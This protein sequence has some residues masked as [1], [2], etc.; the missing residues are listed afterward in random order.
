MIIRKKPGWLIISLIHL[1]LIVSPLIKTKIE[2]EI[3]V[4]VFIQI[5]RMM[6]SL[7]LALIILKSKNRIN[8]SKN[9]KILARSNAITIKR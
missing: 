4:V 9:D 2:I 3:T 1:R 5:A 8:N 7:P 6:E